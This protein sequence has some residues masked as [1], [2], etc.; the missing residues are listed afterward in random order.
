VRSRSKGFTL[1][2]LLVVIGIIAVLIGVL[3]PALQKARRAA[4]TVQCASNMRQVATGM[5]MYINANKGK[6]P[7]CAVATNDPT[8]PNGFWWATELTRLKYIS[9]PNA[10]SDGSGKPNL[11]QSSVFKCPEGKEP[12]DGGG[13]AGAYPTDQDNNGWRVYGKPTA[14]N[15]G[16][17]SWYQLNSAN[18]GNGNQLGKTSI[19]PFVY[20]N[21]GD[22]VKDATRQRYI[23]L[24]KKA[25]EMV[26]IAEAADAN[27]LLGSSSSPDNKTPRLAARHGKKTADGHDAFT[28]IAFFDG[29]VT[30]LPTQPI[31]KT[32][33]GG[34]TRDTIFYVNKQ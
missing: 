10:Y 18:L 5:V 22:S 15:F 30:L 11:S 32:G 20:F 8:Y 21:N 1:V 27:W 2:E 29:H 6:F 25:S 9:A 19:A 3:L 26:M 24:I 12:E 23:G 28:N 34:F 31:S 17:A 4:A 16:I 14:D 13:S 33:F 7:P